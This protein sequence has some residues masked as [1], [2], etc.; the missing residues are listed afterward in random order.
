ME[1]QVVI[2]RGLPGA[3]KSTFAKLLAGDRGKDIICEADDYHYIDGVYTFVR[4]NLN[5]AHTECYNK[6]E[7]LINNNEPLVIQSNTNTLLRE[8]IRYK[9]YAET[10]GY[11]V[12]VLT[13]ENYH[14]NKNIHN[15]PT[16]VIT[17]MK[18]RFIVNL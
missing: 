10:H 5:K 15:T 7:K 12:T 6:F 4:D 13:V 1:K 14:G 17:R 18:D 8:F 9:E 2:L 11:K 16:D 3:G